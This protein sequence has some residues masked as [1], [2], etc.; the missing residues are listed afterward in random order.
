M[1]RKGTSSP[2]DPQGQTLSM[3]AVRVGD[4]PRTL[5]FPGNNK[6]LLRLFEVRSASHLPGRGQ[7]D[8]SAL[9]VPRSGRCFLRIAGFTR[10]CSPH[11]AV[12]TSVS[13]LQRMCDITYTWTNREGPSVFSQLTPPLWKSEF[14][15]IF[16]LSKHFFKHV[17]MLVMCVSVKELK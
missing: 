17:N 15:L 14:V 1:S 6:W 8:E 3:G 9:S 16:Y 2:R 10:P 7:W 12:S 11:H 13:A 5:P 4:G